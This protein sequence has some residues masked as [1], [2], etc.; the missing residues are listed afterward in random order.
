MTHDGFTLRVASDFEGGHTYSVYKMSLTFDQNNTEKE[1]IMDNFAWHDIMINYGETSA[2]VER[3]IYHEEFL[4]RT[5]DK[6][7]ENIWMELT[8]EETLSRDAVSSVFLSIFPSD[9]IIK[10]NIALQ[11]YSKIFLLEEI[12]HQFPDVIIDRIYYKIQ[13]EI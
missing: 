6:I 13:C 10:A 3:L 9:L 8:V 1:I 5:C 4:N 7:A 12:I 2:D 11:D